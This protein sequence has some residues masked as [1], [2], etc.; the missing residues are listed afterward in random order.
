MFQ[1]SF[2]QANLVHF[3]V[4]A[5][6]TRV[7]LTL[8]S[9]WIVALVGAQIAEAFQARFDVVGV[10]DIRQISEYHFERIHSHHLLQDHADGRRLTRFRHCS[11]SS[12][13]NTQWQCD[14]EHRECIDRPTLDHDCWNCSVVSCIYLFLV[15]MDNI[16][17]C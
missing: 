13:L 15:I 14:D 9:V 6:R 17:C 10:L 3:D 12:A 4:T 7:V 2:V 8:A 11:C 1:T 16:L 5:T